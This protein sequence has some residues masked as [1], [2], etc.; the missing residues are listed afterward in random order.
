MKVVR[1]RVTLAPERA[2]SDQ[3][4]GDMLEVLD[5]QFLA[6]GGTTWSAWA[7]DVHPPAPATSEQLA[8][9]RVRAQKS[10]A[11]GEHGG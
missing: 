2:S 3:I 1:A 11:E 4:R 10:R 5:W 6:P 8:R 9:S 7:S